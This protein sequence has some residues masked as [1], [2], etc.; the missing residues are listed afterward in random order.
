M[1]GEVVLMVVFSRVEG[2]EGDELGDN[3]VRPEVEGGEFSHH[4]LSGGLLLLGVVEDGG[5]VPAA[6]IG[7]LTVEGGG[8]MDGEVDVQQVGEV[9]DGTG[10]G[11]CEG[12]VVNGLGGPVGKHYKLE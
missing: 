3:G 7:A 5:A 8:V 11:T 1:A 6:D 10:A 9:T 4:S 2:F 12:D